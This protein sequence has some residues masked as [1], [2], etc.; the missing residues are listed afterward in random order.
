LT[1]LGRSDAI[2][3]LPL[4]WDPFLHFERLWHDV[5]DGDYNLPIEVP[6]MTRDDTLEV[7]RR[8]QAAWNARDPEALARAYA[9]DGIVISPIFS[10]VQGRSEIVESFRALFTTFPDWQ[11]VGQDLLVDGNTVAES[12]IVTATHAGEF[13][14]LP[15]SGR[16]FEIQGVR[17][18]KMKDGL[19]AYERRYYDFTGLLI[20]LG[21]LRGK[22]ARPEQGTSGLNA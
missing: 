5:R 10:T 21:V 19:I 7:F 9:A 8:Q 16:K 1:P 20:Q 15:G 3:D 17:I 18:L 13:M 2:A 11:Y 4:G 12:F 6:P 22:P 14:G